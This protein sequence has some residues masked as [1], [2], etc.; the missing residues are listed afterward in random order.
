MDKLY[1]Q[2]IKSYADDLNIHVYRMMQQGISCLPH[3][4]EYQFPETLPQN[5]YTK[6]LEYSYFFRILQ[7]IFHVHVDLNNGSIFYSNPILKNY[8]NAIITIAKYAEKSDQILTVLN[9]FRAGENA[10]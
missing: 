6:V 8:D 7:Y 10:R 9:Y 3:L 5:Q 4:G 2:A 1:L